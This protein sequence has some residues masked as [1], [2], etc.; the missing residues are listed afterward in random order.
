MGARSCRVSDKQVQSEEWMLVRRHFCKGRP[1]KS[2]ESRS[3]S[4][5]PSETQ[6]IPVRVL[7]P[8]EA[9][10]CSSRPPPSTARGRATKTVSSCHAALANAK[11]RNTGRRERKPFFPH[12]KFQACANKFWKPSLESVTWHYIILKWS[13]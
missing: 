7:L 2:L 9:S 5:W 10:L 12:R 8:T 13:A 1:K 3:L 11:G 6:A 4:G